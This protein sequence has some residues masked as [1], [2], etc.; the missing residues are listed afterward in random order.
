ME[1]ARRSL[2]QAAACLAGL[3]SWPALAQQA[4][5]RRYALLVGV[6]ALQHQPRSLWLQGP[7]HD[8]Q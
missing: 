8:V 5:G 6:G 4:A 7:S 1:P 2:L 3:G